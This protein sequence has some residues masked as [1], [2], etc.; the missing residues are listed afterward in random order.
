MDRL[1]APGGA[2]ADS[3]AGGVGAGIFQAGAV[4]WGI[5]FPWGCGSPFCA[6]GFSSSAPNWSYRYTRMARPVGNARSPS[7]L[8]RG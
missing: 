4:A 5:V 3:P 2:G 6:W 1:L 8:S 7:G